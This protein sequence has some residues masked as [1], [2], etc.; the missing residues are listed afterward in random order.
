MIG[1]A[2]GAAVSRMSPSPS[3]GNSTRGSSAVAGIGIGSVIQK[4]A[5]RAAAPA[6]RQPSIESPSGGPMISVV[7]RA[8][9]P[10]AH[11]AHCRVPYPFAVLSSPSPGAPDG[12]VFESATGVSRGRPQARKDIGCKERWSGLMPAR[13]T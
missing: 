10:R 4:M 3:T 5:M 11:P 6:V 13:L 1:L 2:N 9:G 7:S 8:A 12:C